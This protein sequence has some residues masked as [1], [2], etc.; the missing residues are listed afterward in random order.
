MTKTAE[1][2]VRNGRVDTPA[3]YPSTRN[4]FSMWNF[5]ALI[6]WLSKR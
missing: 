3:E 6:P 5:C 4:S 2:E 1:V